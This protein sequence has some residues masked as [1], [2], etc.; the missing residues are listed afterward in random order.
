MSA[1]DKSVVRIS[2][3]VDASAQD[4]WDVL[5]DGWFYPM[6]VVGAARMRDVDPDWPALGS[7]LH[8]SV[9]N[10][11]MLLDDKT[12]VLEVDPPRLL[13][14]KT[15]GWPAG[16]AEVIL[17]VDAVGD[18]HSK[19]H[20]REDAV[21][22]PGSLVPKPARQMLIGPRNRETLRRLA[23]LVEGRARGRGT[24]D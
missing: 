8:H 10:W 15:H 22:G 14:L 18:S 13:R 24:A 21:E 23:L 6:W 17:E 20:I 7:R 16:A 4:V 12:E 19:I 3:D 5:A 2:R 9:G 11:P 1:S